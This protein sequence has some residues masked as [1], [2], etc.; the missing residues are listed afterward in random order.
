MSNQHECCEAFVSFANKAQMTGLRLPQRTELLL[1]D[2][3]SLEEI[4]RFDH[5][6]IPEGVVHARGA[7]AFGTFKMHKSFLYNLFVISTNDQQE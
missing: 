3:A 7:G 6:R 1:E 4:H 5:E 2:H